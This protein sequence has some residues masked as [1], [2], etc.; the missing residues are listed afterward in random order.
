MAGL[1]RPELDPAWYVEEGQDIS[2]EEVCSLEELEALHNQRDR[3][4]RTR[5]DADDDVNEEDDIG[6]G[7]ETIQLDENIGL[8][9][10]VV[11]PDKKSADKSMRRWCDANFCPLAKVIKVTS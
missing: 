1:A 10:G 5:E 2:L 11:F 4:D 8:K 3:E 9:V 7:D 6:P